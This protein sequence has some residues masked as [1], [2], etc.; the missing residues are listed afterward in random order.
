MFGCCRREASILEDDTARDVAALQGEL[1]LPQ[2]LEALQRLEEL[3]Q[4]H[5]LLLPNGA[6]LPLPIPVLQLQGSYKHL[7]KVPHNPRAR[8]HV[9]HVTLDKVYRDTSTL[10]KTFLNTRRVPFI[11]LS[12]SLV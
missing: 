4:A 6:T 10:I 11:Y 1:D 9:P 5:G 3:A 7:L 8:S 2:V 12:K